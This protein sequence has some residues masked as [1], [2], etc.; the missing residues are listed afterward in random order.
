M[1]NYWDWLPRELQKYI[2]RLSQLHTDI[3]M[4]T[5]NVGGYY[6]HNNKSGGYHNKYHATY[7]WELNLPKDKNKNILTMTW[8]WIFDEEYPVTPQK[9]LVLNCFGRVIT[10]QKISSDPYKIRVKFS[11]K[12]WDTKKK[13]AIV[14]Y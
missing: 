12:N 2:Y 3:D 4:E 10:Y 7:F 8:T 13:Q 6:Q 11:K 1:V 14:K 5:W 9:I